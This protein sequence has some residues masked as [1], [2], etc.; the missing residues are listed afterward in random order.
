MKK[1]YFSWRR[2]GFKNLFLLSSACVLASF[3]PK[4]SIDNP[5]AK[6]NALPFFDPLDYVQFTVTGFTEDVVANGVGAASVTTTNSVDAANYVFAAYGTQF[7]EGGSSVTTGLPSDGILTNSSNSDLTF[8]LADYSEN[9]V[10]RLQ[11]QSSEGS[12]TFAETGS[13][14][15]IYMAVTSG[16]GASTVSG[17]IDF[18]DGT[19]Q[20]FS[21]L[22]VSDWFGGSNPLIS[23]IG[24]KSRTTT[25]AFESNSSNPRIYQLTVVVDAANQSKTVTGITITKDSSG[26]VFNL[27]A[28]TGKLA[29]DCQAPT[30]VTEDTVNAFDATFSWTG[31]A[32][33][34]TFEVAIV[35]GGAE[36]PTSGIAVSVETYQFADLDPETSYD[37]Y[38]RTVCSVSGYSYWAGPYNF[39]TP[40]SCV[41]P[42]EITISAIETTSA[43]VTWTAGSED[44]DT[45]EYVLQVAGL[46]A[47]ESGEETSETSFDVTELA[48]NTEYDVYV[49]ANCGEANG[50][51]SWTMVTFVTACEAFTAIDE[52]FEDEEFPNC[53]S[54]IN[55]GG[56]NQ[57]VVYNSESYAHTGSYSMRLTYNSTAHN[58][59]LIT[60]AFTVVDHVSDMISFWSKSYSDY[61][62]EEF[63]VLVSTTGNE[64][65]D[66]TDIIASSVQPGG[67]Y[68][69]Y[70]YNLSAYE[71]QTIYFAIQ[72]VS[73]NELYLSV[74]DIKTFAEP[75]CLVPENIVSSAI[76]SDS[77]TVSWDM[78]DNTAWEIAYVESGEE[79]PESGTAVTE[80]TYEFTEMIPNTTFDVYVR[81]DCGEEDGYSEWVSIS[82][83]TAC[84]ATTMI[85]EGFEGGELPSCWSVINGGGAN[86]WVIYNSESYAHT[87][88]YS[89]RL[90]YNSTAH[91]D[92]LISPPFTVESHVSDMVSFWSKSYSDYWAEEF[93]VLVS[94]TGN[95]ETDF[96]DVIAS[97]VQPGGTYTKYEYDLSAYEGQTIYFAIQAV[98]TNEY[99]LSIDDFMTFGS[100]YC[101]APTDLTATDI[102][103][104][105]A[106]LSWTDDESTSWEIVVQEEGSG[107]PTEAG[108]L[109]EATTYESTYSAGT[110]SEFY[111]RSVCADG[112]NYSPWSGPFSYGG[113]TSLEISG[114]QNYDVIANGVGSSTTS[115]TNDVD[116]ANYAYIS[117]DFKVNESDDDLTYGLPVSGVISSPNTAGLSYQMSDYSGN[118][119]LRI[120]TSGADNGG[121]MTIAAAQPAEKL[122][123][124]VTSGS[125]A[126]D[127]TGSINFTDGTSQTIYTNTVPNWF[128]SSDLPVAISGIGRINLTN[129][130]LENPSG[131]PRLYEIEVLIGQIHHEKTIGS[132]TIQKDSGDGVVNVFAASIK[133]SS[134]AASVKDVNASLVKVYPNPVQDKLSI[135]GVD[136]T[137]V[138]VYN[139]LGQQ[140]NVKLNNNVVDMAGLETGVYL[141]TIHAAN[142]T[143]TIR[144]I[145]K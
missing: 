9:N 74:D 13:Y 57:W 65:E 137:S 123:L 109:V 26:G 117:A 17:T 145:K 30:D 83:T 84:E 35:E 138:E 134:A 70:E 112:V 100:D 11:T 72:A 24:R 33:G 56:S 28:V 58:D 45:F 75:Y 47:P 53:W 39:T 133:Y 6:S 102:T 101:A 80:A 131:N 118:N 135:S 111:V 61:W 19:T 3:S 27:F 95:Y 140:M 110:V 36:A 59:F 90:S 40:V 29:A 113:Y 14:E 126:G 129:D 48:S 106:T 115:T 5:P 121:T 43:T 122:Y 52:S 54:I 93:N 1:N 96:T 12:V 41:A 91:D 99:Y 144:V 128:N 125:G 143:E 69:E 10:L 8:Q 98:S 86:Q 77:F 18:E 114:G 15:T 7:T 94:T 103:P 141:V 119:S 62:G 60:P 32:E 87:G 92:Y 31:Y 49:R 139:M 20:A 142:A 25:A 21:S 71:G 79:A 127:I 50:Y 51:S 104:T 46:D 23:G 81:T 16:D 136:A 85:D 44:Q 76:T 63:N 4:S 73:T 22:S 116:G 105:T 37:V 108:T 132:I 68:T 66:F 97:S 64:E 82:V 2:K 42:T 67:T 78:G 89:M 130:N 38:V 88:S 34:D 120:E 107:E 124:L 55:G